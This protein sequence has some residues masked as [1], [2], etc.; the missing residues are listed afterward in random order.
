MNFHTYEYAYM[1]RAK[2]VKMFIMGLQCINMKPSAATAKIDVN[3]FIVQRGDGSRLCA[4]QP[5]VRAR[6]DR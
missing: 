2:R 5:Q 4:R 1:K 3:R 6:P